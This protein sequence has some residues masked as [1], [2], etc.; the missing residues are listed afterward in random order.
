MQGRGRQTKATDHQP[1]F[2]LFCFIA[3]EL[4]FYIFGLDLPVG[5]QS[6][7]YLLSGSLKVCCVCA[8]SH[9][10]LS[11]PLDYSPPRSSVH[12]IF[13]A[14]I[15]EWVALP[16]SRGSSQPR[17]WT[18]VF[19]ISGELFTHWTIREAQNFVDPC[20]IE[21]IYIFI[22]CCLYWIRMCK[23]LGQKDLYLNSA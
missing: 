16:F 21:Y 1:V 10:T 19:C 5:T 9:P 12:G 17:D 2:V 15:L 13:Q 23:S 22:Y 7:R 3:L 6:L 4:S 18:W 14:R 11:D 8:Q 20:F